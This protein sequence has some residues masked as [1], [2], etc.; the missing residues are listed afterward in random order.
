MKD[1]RSFFLPLFIGLALFFAV[2][3]FAQNTTPTQTK[4]TDS[5]CSSCGGDSCMKEGMKNAEGDGCCCCAGDSCAK[6][7]K[8]NKNHADAEGGCCCSSDSCKM[9]DMKNHSGSSESCCA[10]GASGD[11]SRDMK[12]KHDKRHQASAEGCCCCSGDSCKKTQSSV[13]AN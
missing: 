6:K 1:I 5:C 3:A 2:A 9:K 10:A 4:Q 11:I 8:E 12:M 13:P 7:M